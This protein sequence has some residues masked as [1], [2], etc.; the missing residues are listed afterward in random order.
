[1]ALFCLTCGYSN[2]TPQPVV[3]MQKV[4]KETINWHY[5]SDKR[6]K[7]AQMD[8]KNILI[9]F[10]MRRCQYCFQFKD[11]TLKDPALIR[12]LNEQFVP[13]RVDDFDPGFLDTAKKFNV[14]S[15]P[16]VVI[17][18]YVNGAEIIRSNSYLDVQTM[19]MALDVSIIISQMLETTSSLQD[20]LSIFNKLMEQQVNEN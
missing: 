8:K 19:N 1:M 17:F 4:K 10:S 13:I 9:F 3:P 15:V 20:T 2:N 14:N 18:S 6:I 12:K 7:I 16:T 5:L 11:T